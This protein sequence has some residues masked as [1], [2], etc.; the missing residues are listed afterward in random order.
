MNNKIRNF[1]TRKWGFGS[2]ILN[3]IKIAFY[4]NHNG[5]TLNLQDRNNTIGVGF[6]LFSV[7]ELPEFIK[8]ISGDI[9]VPIENVKSLIKYILYDS[10]R[11]PIKLKY[12]LW[13]LTH[14]R[15]ELFLSKFNSDK[16]VNSFFSENYKKF[17]GIGF[18]KYWRY[19]EKTISIFRDYDQNFGLESF[20]PDISVQVRGGD[21]L[22]EISE[23]GFE[24]SLI[25]QY[26]EATILA[27]SQ[28]QKVT[29]NIYI[30]TDTYSYFIY[31][32]D[33]LLMLYPYLQI[34]SLAK[35][36]QEGYSQDNFNVLNKQ[37]KIDAYYLF[38]YELEKL[39]IAKVCVGSYTSNIYYLASLIKY[40]AT[41]EFINVG[42]NLEDVYL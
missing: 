27:V 32:K 7:V 23:M 34:K 22:L 11:L 16:S 12:S 35:D 13:Y 30:M 2:N 29:L 38:L 42:K 25:D 1:T 21:K 17:S 6:S 8:V 10:S 40:D 15:R 4:C 39:R 28:S 37:A 18:S 24:N 26:L 5:L 20:T 41:N 3:F 19:T 33:R 31:L 36:H 14:Y 9:V